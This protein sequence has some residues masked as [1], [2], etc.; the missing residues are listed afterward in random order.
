MK[1]QLHKVKSFVT[2]AKPRI[3][4]MVVMTT[5][6]GF[7]VCSISTN[8]FTHNWIWVCVSVFF[9][10]SSASTF[11]QVIEIETDALM[12]RTSKR[13]LVSG[14][15]SKRESWFFG[16]VSFLL[17]MICMYLGANR[18]AMVI[19]CI[20]FFSYVLLYTPMKTRSTLNTIV[21][22]V[23][24]ALPPLIGWVAVSGRINLGGMILFMILFL[25]Q[26]PHF[27]AI[28]WMYRDEYKNAGMSM[29]TEKKGSG[30]FVAGHAL[31]YTVALIS[32]AMLPR[33]IDMAGSLYFFGS[34]FLG[35]CFALLVGGFVWKQNVKSAR[36]VL[37]GSVLYLPAL[38][39]LLMID[40]L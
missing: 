36:R 35:L 40:A 7:Y 31:L 8:Q 25:W 24:G 19:L 10:A 34:L 17:G 28:A 33:L 38:F 5:F 9:M 23:P 29:I 2:L 27:L 22:A 11:N 1:S 39:G 20:T 16:V 21:G 32:V 15:L 37:L 13:P 12:K 3:S 26:L 14:V 6:T 30:P 4:L 18:V